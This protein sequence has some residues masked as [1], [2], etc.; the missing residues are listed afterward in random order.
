MESLFSSLV[1]EIEA[2]Y[3][4]LGHK[5]GWRF[6]YTPKRTLSSETKLATVGINPGGGAWEEPSSSVEAGNAYR[7]EVWPGN[8]PTLQAQIQ[9]IYQGVAFKIGEPSSSQLMDETLAA[10]FYPFRSS[11]EG[12]LESDAASRA[13][14]R[15]LWG[16]ILRHVKPRVWICFGR[17]PA[18]ELQR[19]LRAAGWRRVETTGG[20][21]VGWSDWTYELERY[22]HPQGRTLLVRLP[23]LSY[24]VFGRP[25]SQAA[26]E[27]ITSAIAAA[28]TNDDWSLTPSAET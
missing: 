16:R 23:H 14:S 22:D 26:F 12:R 15:Q 20:V 24:P 18:H 21:R 1:E 28:I 13:F 11:R 4:R 5:H 19:L 2:A 6:L 25:S 8:G 10:N 17:T 27:R 9:L 3:D 7:T